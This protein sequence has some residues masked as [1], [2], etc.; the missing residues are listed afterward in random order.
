MLFR[1]DYQY[2]GDLAWQ[3]VLPGSVWTEERQGTNGVGTCINIGKSGSIVGSQHYGMATQSLTCLTSP[4]FGRHGM[5]ESVINVTTA[6]SG[7]ERMNRVV[8]NIVERSAGWIENGYFGRLHR[9]NHMLRLVENAETADLAEE[10]RIALDDNGLILGT[11][12]YVAKLLG[13]P[14][15]QLIG[16]RAEELFDL[17]ASLS[18]IRPDR[19]VSMGFAGKTLQAMLATPE[20]R[21]QRATVVPGGFA[22][23]APLCRCTRPIW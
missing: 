2:M 21:Q 12:S 5:I 17:G 6:R 8:Q 13:R 15:E 11:S 4:V 9:Q 7:D 19:P 23:T 20:T 1:C 18:D 14:V 3:G 16:A 10:G 22:P